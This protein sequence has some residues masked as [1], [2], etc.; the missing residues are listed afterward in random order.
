MRLKIFNK[1][2]KK[3]SNNKNLKLKEIFIDT[4]ILERSQ[5]QSK[6]NN[7]NFIEEEISSNKIISVN[8]RTI[9]QIKRKRKKDQFINLRN[10]KDYVIELDSVSKAY[11]VGKNKIVK[12]INNLNLKIS[13]GEFVVLFGKSGSG[14][15]TLLNIMSGLDRA[16]FGNVIV[17]NVNLPYLS[18]E[19]L[20]NFRRKNISFVFQQ[21]HLLNNITAYE[22]VE[23]G[24]I[25]QKNKNEVVD[26]KK[27]FEDF[28]LTELMNKYPSQ[29]SGG[30]Q[31]RISIMRALAKNSDIIF[32]DEPTSA[33]DEKSG[34]A[35]MEI[36]KKINKEQ[37]KTIILVSHNP[38]V[39]KYAN[40]KIFLNKG[41]IEKDEI[42]N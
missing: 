39:A 32:A 7:N 11:I 38:D 28:E 34:T 10:K 1:L 24:A 30:Q 27:M 40:R 17:N 42:I 14:K 18:N 9:K 13:K 20:T 33:L 15:S 31:Q 6:Q 22:N 25:L 29:M 5:E 36:F 4:D 26:I 8:R 12:V 41:K 23:T 16:T 37:G 35:I 2:F 19:E 3:K 21:H